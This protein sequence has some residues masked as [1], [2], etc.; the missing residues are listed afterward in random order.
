MAHSASGN[1]RLGHRAPG[2]GGRR[3][4]I[5]F[6]A[7]PAHL[8]SLGAF[9]L[10]ELRVFWTFLD[11]LRYICSSHGC[12]T[13]GAANTSC[14][15]SDRFRLR[16]LR[17][18]QHFTGHLF[19]PWIPSPACGKGGG[20]R[21]FTAIVLNVSRRRFGG[22]AGVEPQSPGEPGPRRG[23][24]LIASPSRSNLSAPGLR[25]ANARYQTNAVAQGSATRSGITLLYLRPYSPRLLAK[26]H[27]V[28]TARIRVA[29]GGAGDDAPDPQATALGLPCGQPQPPKRPF[30]QRFA[31]NHGGDQ[32]GVSMRPI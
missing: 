20:P 10:F 28:R 15:S 8:S 32:R 7:L 21:R 13:Q 18:S 6:K 5:P 11:I 29:G 23:G 4:S 17:E 14:P 31:I 24:P 9:C 26:L 3:A 16:E 12:P 25:P 2:R 27:R 1:L 30:P 22:P 19:R